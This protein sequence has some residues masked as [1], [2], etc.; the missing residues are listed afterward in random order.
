MQT[1]ASKTS[2]INILI[3]TQWVSELGL[4]AVTVTTRKLVFLDANLQ[5]EIQS[6]GDEPTKAAPE[7]LFAQVL[8]MQISKS[9]HR[10]I[11]AQQM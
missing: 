2:L 9:R 8:T 6:S 11:G 3:T 10:G 4:A 7:K 5:T 1:P